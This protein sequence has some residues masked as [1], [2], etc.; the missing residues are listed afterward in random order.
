MNI[1]EEA[2]ISR[3]EEQILLLEK[4]CNEQAV[5]TV[6]VVGELR[7][8]ITRLRDGLREALGLCEMPDSRFA[9]EEGASKI[10]RLRALLPPEE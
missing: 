1:Y 2:E 5:E 6:K 7:L 4:A 9:H 10:V 8:E 3:K